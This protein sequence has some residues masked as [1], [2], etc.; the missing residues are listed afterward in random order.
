MRKLGP[1]EQ[2]LDETM[3]AMR[4]GHSPTHDHTMMGRFT[5]KSP[6]MIGVCDSLDANLV[7]GVLQ[8]LT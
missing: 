8:R 3:R 6:G 2:H 7:R 1:P 5:T 4:Y